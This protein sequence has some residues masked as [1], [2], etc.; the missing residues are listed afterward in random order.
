MPSLLLRSTALTELSLTLH[1]LLRSIALVQLPLTL[2]LNSIF[3]VHLPMLLP[4]MRIKLHLLL[5]NIA[6]RELPLMLLRSI[7]LAQLPWL[8][9]RRM[10]VKMTLPLLRSVLI[11][12]PLTLLQSSIALSVE[13]L[14]PLKA[15]LLFRATDL[16]RPL[17]RGQLPKPLLL[18]RRHLL[19]LCRT[20]LLDRNRPLLLLVAALLGRKTVLP[21]SSRLPRP[22][23][24]TRCLHTLGHAL[25]LS[26]NRVDQAWLPQALLPQARLG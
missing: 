22:G 9:L 18:L 26:Q 7:A 1:L 24:R 4:S 12:L 25:L 11:E 13:L 14:P 20:L 19:S 10:L 3:L 2:L 23:K 8:L 16:L 17:H 15:L 5:R 21:S 6:S